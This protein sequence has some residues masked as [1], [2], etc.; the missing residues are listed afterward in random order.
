MEKS[1][2]TTSRKFPKKKLVGGFGNYCCVS[3]CKIAFYDK[4]RGN[5]NTSLFKIPKRKD[6]RM[7]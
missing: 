4:N 3:G 7:K 5:T 6:L 2:S 1:S